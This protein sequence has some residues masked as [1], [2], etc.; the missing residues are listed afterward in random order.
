MSERK[1]LFSV[2]KKDLEVTWYAPKGP[3]GQK[4]NKT[5]NACRI[6]HPESG[7]LVT[8]SERRERQRNI[9]TALRRLV[10]HPKFKVW[11]AKRC[12][13]EVDKLEGQRKIEEIVEEQMREHNLKVEIKEDGK[14][15]APPAQ[16]C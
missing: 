2:T 3:G 1:L 6:K 15:A 7:A 10:D 9:S 12:R 4:K 13:E 5:N 14:W 11:H 16:D 8:A